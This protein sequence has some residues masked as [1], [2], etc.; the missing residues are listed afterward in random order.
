MKLQYFKSIHLEN[1]I[2]NKKPPF[3][4]E[5]Y[6]WYH[7]VGERVARTNVGSWHCGLPSYFGGST[8]NICLLYRTWK[9][10]RNEKFK[11]NQEGAAIL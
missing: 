7:A 10:I 2:A 11:F 3:A 9:K 4:I 8:P 1:P 6:N 5:I